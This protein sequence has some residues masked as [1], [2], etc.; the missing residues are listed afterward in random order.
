MSEI[1]VC[2]EHIL[3]YLGH[4]DCAR[5]KYLLYEFAQ[6]KYNWNFLKLRMSENLTSDIGTSEICM[7]QGPSVILM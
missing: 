6:A 4:A 3:E 7:S 2:V 1:Q 5:A